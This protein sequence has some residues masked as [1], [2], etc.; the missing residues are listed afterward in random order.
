MGQAK[1]WTTQ[2]L[3]TVSSYLTP[4]S[5]SPTGL[6]WIRSCGRAKAGQAAGTLARNGYYRTMLQ[7]RYWMNHRLV[8]MLSNQ[9][10]SCL[11]DEADHIDRNK[12]NNALRNLRWVSKSLNCARISRPGNNTGYKYVR[13][14]SGAS[15]YTYQIKLNGIRYYEGRFRTAE[16]AYYA[17]LARKLQESWIPASPAS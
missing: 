1:S 8:L 2:E 6:R 16:E 5:G 7:G 10:P 13:P 11:R 9:H 14:Q 17:A 15:T 12:Q 3:E 4:D